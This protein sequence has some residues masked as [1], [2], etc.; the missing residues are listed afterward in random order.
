M[1]DWNQLENR[2][3][4]WRPRRP[5]AKLRARLFPQTGQSVTE[6]LSRTA[7]HWLA[8]AMAMCLLAMMMLGNSL[9]RSP[10]WS[11]T[12]PSNL[13]AAVVLH[14]PELASYY[15][16]T[17]E[18]DRNILPKDAFDWTNGSYALTTAAPLSDT[19]RSRP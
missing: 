4:S 12:Q 9:P 17:H 10:Y 5:S 19:N 6:M 3:R 2:L 1:N 7:R 14:R 11:P 18:Y 16:G 15:A 13:L 8:P